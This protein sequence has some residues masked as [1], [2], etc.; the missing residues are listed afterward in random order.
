[1]SPHTALRCLGPNPWN[2]A[3][4]DPCRRPTDG[5][6]A[7]N[8]HRL[9]HYFQYQVVMKP[10]PSNIPDVYIQSLMAIGLHPSDHDIRFVEDNWE[11]P[12]LGAWGVGWEVWLNGMEVTQFTY[13]QQCG[14]LPCEPTS[15]EITYGLERLAM[16]IQQVDH[17]MDI[18]WQVDASGT[19][20]TY[21]DI[22]RESE[23]AYSDY[24]FNHANTSR[25]M[26]L[27]DSYE[28]ESQACMAANLVFP[29]FDYCLKCSHA[30]NILD[31]RG[32]IAVTERMGYILRI[33]E[34]AFQ[35]AN[36]YVSQETPHDRCPA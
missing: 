5:R 7:Q 13:F 12:T 22:Y 4:V 28:Q 27:F 17:V 23:I 34:L 35:C 31:A 20:I 10:S 2:V 24:N 18:Q 15:V 8:P 29:A 19:P 32:A 1:M 11:S 6:Y 25:L 26:A 3:Y 36:H 9:Q 16:Y 14:G 30:F 33:R 21:G